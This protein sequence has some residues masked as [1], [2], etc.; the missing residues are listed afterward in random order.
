M[1]LLHPALLS[2]GPQWK[3]AG[4]HRGLRGG[5]PAEIAEDDPYEVQL[6][7]DHWDDETQ[8]ETVLESLKAD[9]EVG[10]GRLPGSGYRS[11]E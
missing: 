1:V 7:R 3:L 2:S 8:R 6:P 9:S 4:V 10:A 5:M 11:I